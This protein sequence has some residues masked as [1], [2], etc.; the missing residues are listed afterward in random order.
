MYA[1]IEG[2]I[3][4]YTFAVSRRPTLCMRM[5]KYSPVHHG[6]EDYARTW[7]LIMDYATK[8]NIDDVLR[9]HPPEVAI[10]TNG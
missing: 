8:F 4:K 1:Y 6:Y 2:I 9:T 7:I 3:S 5:H 10:I